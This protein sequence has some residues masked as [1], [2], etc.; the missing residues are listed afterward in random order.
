MRCCKIFFLIAI[1]KLRYT[2]IEVHIRLPLCH[3]SEYT[4]LSNMPVI[5]NATLE[6]GWVK[7]VYDVTPVMS[8]YLLAFVVADFKAQEKTTESGLQ[9]R[10]GV[11]LAND[12]DR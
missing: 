6:D 12:A 2:F 10:A 4:A 1:I 9:V 3:V 11:T 7:E 8:T 5:S